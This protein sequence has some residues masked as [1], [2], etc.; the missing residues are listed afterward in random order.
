MCYKLLDEAKLFFSHS[1]YFLEFKYPINLGFSFKK[2]KLKL[3]ERPNVFKVR[4]QFMN[5]QELLI[6]NK[7]Y[8]VL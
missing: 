7:N 6:N 4:E 5:F 8:S 1:K 2:T 3:N